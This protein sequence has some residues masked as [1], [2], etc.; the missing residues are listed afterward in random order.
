MSPDDDV[1]AG[2][3]LTVNVL[4]TGHVAT[5]HRLFDKEGRSLADAGVAVRIFADHPARERCNGVELVPIDRG[6]GRMTRFLVAPWRAFRA[7]RKHPAPIVHIHDAELLQICPLLKL[8]GQPIIVYDVHEDF[9]NLMLRRDWIPKPIRMMA[10]GMLIAAEHVLAAS[11]DGI[12]SVTQ[13]LA[14]KF[15]RHPR[16]ALYNL[17]SRAFIARAGEAA[18]PPSQRPIDVMH[19]GVLTNERMEFLAAALDGLLQLRPAASFRIVGPLPHQVEWLRSRFAEAN[20]DIRGKVPYDEVPGM[21]RACKMGVN[22]HPIL[23]PHLKVAVPVKVLEYMACGCGV[24][25]SWLPELDALLADETKADLTILRDTGPE[26][27]GNALADWIS[28]ADRLD[29]ASAR[30]MVAA[31]ER[32]SW[33][34]QAAKLPAFYR[35]LLA[36]WERK[37]GAVRTAPAERE[38]R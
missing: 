36:E 23:Y 18:A 31:R 10:R 37:R 26:A 12:V 4:S 16:L 29:E 7:A 17:P 35:M 33:E 28:D 19:L 32:Y 8:C 25:T 1:R 9:G 24:V 27:Y 13:S 2:E 11:V 22:V 14:D 5:D 3:P 6:S 15:S 34:S 30:L 20:A 21:V 38:S